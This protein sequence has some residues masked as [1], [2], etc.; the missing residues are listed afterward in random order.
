MALRSTPMAA[1]YPELFNRAR[2]VNGWVIERRT[3]RDIADA[4][5]CDPKLITLAVARFGLPRG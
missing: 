4:P 2:I 3:A 5:G 1:T